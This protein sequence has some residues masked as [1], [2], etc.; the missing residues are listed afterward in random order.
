MVKAILE[1]WK[2]KTRRIIKPQ[3]TTAHFDTSANP[4]TW[5]DGI[6]ELQC[7][8]GKPGDHLWVR[9]T[10]QRFRSSGRGVYQAAS[11][12]NGKLCPNCVERLGTWK[13]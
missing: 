12:E 1:D 3:P 13:T 9:D 2:T 4:P 10:W 5:Y 6:K 11:N 8:Y 7:P